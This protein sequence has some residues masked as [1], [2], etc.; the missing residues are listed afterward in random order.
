MVTIHTPVAV[1]RVFEMEEG[2]CM[3]TGHTIYEKDAQ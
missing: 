3:Q 2:I 1:D